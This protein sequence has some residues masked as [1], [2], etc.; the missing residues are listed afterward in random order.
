MM[1]N[2]LLVPAGI[3]VGLVFVAAVA[4]GGMKFPEAVAWLLIG[5]VLGW[6]SNRSLGPVKLFATAVLVVVIAWAVDAGAF[7]TMGA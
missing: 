3:I 2:K 5:A 4:I 1:G 7:G 6:A